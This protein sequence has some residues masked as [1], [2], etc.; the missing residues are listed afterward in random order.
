MPCLTQV[1]GVQRRAAKLILSPGW[2]LSDQK[3]K[4]IDHELTESGMWDCFECAECDLCCTRTHG[5]SVYWFCLVTP[6][7]LIL[8]VNQINSSVE[9]CGCMRLDCLWFVKERGVFLKDEWWVLNINNRKK[10]Q[11]LVRFFIYAS[12]FALSCLFVF[13]QI[14]LHWAFLHNNVFTVMSLLSISAT[15]VKL[16]IVCSFLIMSLVSP[17]S[18]LCVSITVA[19][20]V[21]RTLGLGRLR[22]HAP[23]HPCQST[24]VRVILKLD[25]IFISPNSF[26]QHKQALFNVVK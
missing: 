6:S 25:F 23:S 5:S 22:Q 10:V 26:T 4:A 16:W 21:G 8:R 14:P 7:A 9:P 1:P 18:V 24:Q 13:P 20:A 2:C 19:V 17:F 12:I 3:G 11:L 15:S